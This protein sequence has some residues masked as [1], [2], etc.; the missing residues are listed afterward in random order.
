MRTPRHGLGVV[1]R[2]R[3]VYAIE[4]GDK[5]GLFY[6]DAIEMLDV[7]PANG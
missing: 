4:G 5:P 7:Q 6:S 2:G 3:R 1:A